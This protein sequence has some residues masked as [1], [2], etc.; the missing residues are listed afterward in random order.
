MLE[1]RD[2]EGLIP[3]AGTMC[4]LE[5]VLE[6]DTNRI[7][8]ATTTHRAHANPLR[9]AQHLHAVHL[10]EYGAQTMAIHG[11]LI[12]RA[13]GSRAQPGMLVSLRDVELYCDDLDDLPGELHI[14]AHSLL[15][16]E[17]SWQYRFEARH[18]RTL[19]GSG[20]A[21]IIAR[22]PFSSSSAPG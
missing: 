5:R 14:E 22:A 12:A 16:S 13:A 20:R 2:F 11:G 7:L 19:L 21:A 15:V 18:G 9:L 3:H 4:L 1:R 17:S 8:A 6:W 10:C